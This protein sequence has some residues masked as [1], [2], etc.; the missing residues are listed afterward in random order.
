[1]A[2]NALPTVA[3]SDAWTASQHNTYIK[4]NF[5]SVWV[6]TT[7]GDLDYYTSST[8][9]SRLAIGSSYQLL[10]STGTAPAWVSLSTVMA[11]A[12]IVASQA[13]GDLVYASSATAISRLA[14]GTS[15]QLLRSTGSAPAWVSLSTATANTALVASQAAGDLIYA[16]SATAASAISIGASGSILRS[17]G[18]IPVWYAPGG[19]N[20]FLRSVSSS[21]SWGGLVYRRQGGNATNWQTSGSSSYTPLSTTI[22]AGVKSITLT[23]GSGSAAVTYPV[24]FTYRPVIFMNVNNGGS[25]GYSVVYGDDTISGFTIYMYDTGLSSATYTVNWIAIGE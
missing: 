7:A 12:A 24:A 11:N 20:T 17:N 13:A 9:K 8:T 5:A 21:S 14:I 16:S 3:T 2:Y 6:G 10:R 25:G 15:Y 4:D 19:D 23:S 18:S 1:M 22:E